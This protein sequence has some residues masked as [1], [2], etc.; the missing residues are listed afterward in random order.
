MENDPILLEKEA[1]DLLEQEKSSEAYACFK[2]AGDAYR[3]K[4]RHKE[5]A[6]CLASAATCW[7]IKSGERTFYNAAAAYRDAA[8]AS[9]S[10]GDLEYASLLYRQAAINFERDLE[11]MNFSECFYLSRE[12]QRRFLLRSLFAP[13]KIHPIGA[14]P[15]REIRGPFRKL[16]LW[17]GLSFSALLWGHGERPYRTFF[18][19]ILFVFLS[20]F[21]YMGGSLL[22]GGVIFKPD[23]WEAF[24]FSVVTFTTLGYGDITPSGLTRGL[25]MLEAFG[26]IFVIP[27]FLVG[28]SRRYLRT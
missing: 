7:A 22:K 9:E 12:C 1:H 4:G 17:L 15:G 23:F 2:K 8:K 5:A 3:E 6:L 20:S 26:G 27:L 14:F 10:A 24:Y 16:I 19:A 11:F 18:V 28:L 21:I 13:Q 25:A